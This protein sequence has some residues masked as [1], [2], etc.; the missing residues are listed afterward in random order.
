MVKQHT[1]YDYDHELT[2]EEKY[3]TPEDWANY[4]SGNSPFAIFAGILALAVCVGLVC[5]FVN[6]CVG[7]SERHTA[8]LAAIENTALEGFEDFDIVMDT[9]PLS[10][11]ATNIPLDDKTLPDFVCTH[12]GQVVSCCNAEFVN[13]MMQSEYFVNGMVGCLWERSYKHHR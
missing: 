12:E 9:E 3:G 7:G 11:V 13:A 2:D 1:G 5:I 6:S 8:D 4:G 10:Y